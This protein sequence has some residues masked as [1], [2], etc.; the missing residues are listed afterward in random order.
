M[1]VAMPDGHWERFAFTATQD[2]LGQWSAMT[3]GAFG[4]VVENFTNQTFTIWDKSASQYYF[5]YV[6]DSWKIK[7]IT[8]INNNKLTL[9]YDSSGKLSTILDTRGRTM[10]LTYDTAGLLKTVSDGLG[11]SVSYEYNADQQL[12]KFIDRNGKPWQYTYA[13]YG[14]AKLLYEI[15]DPL[16]N[17]LLTNTYDDNARVLT[18]KDALGKISGKLWKMDYASSLTT[19]IDPENTTLYYHIDPIKQMVTKV[20]NND[21]QEVKLTHKQTIQHSQDASLIEDTTNPKGYQ[22]KLSYN[23]PGFGNTSTIEDP[24]NRKTQLGWYENRNQTNQNLVESMSLPGITQPYTLNYGTDKKNLESITNPLTN[25]TQFT[26]NDKGQIT[27]VTDPRGHKTIYEYENY[28]LKQIKDTFSAVLDSNWTFNHNYAIVY[29]YDAMGRVQTVKDRN[30]DVMTY[31]YNANDQV[32]KI[33]DPYSKYVQFNYDDSGNLIKVTDKRLNATE[34]QYNTA[35]L[36]WKTIEKVNIGTINAKTYETIY[37]YDGLNRLVK[38]TNTRQNTSETEYDTLGRVSKTYNPLREY[39]EYIYDK[40][41]N[42]ESITYRDSA[43]TVQKSI[44]YAYDSLD[45]KIYD[46]M[47]PGDGRVLKTNYT[48]YETKG[49]LKT[50]QDPR[51]NITEFEYDDL[52][53]VTKVIDAN[54]KKITEV[55]YDSNGNIIE[56]LDPK[57][58]KTSYQYDALNR[59]VK[60]TDLD[61]KSWLYNYD[62][63]G[64]LVYYENPGTY[65]MSYEYYPLNRL[66]KVSYAYNYESV[67]RSESFTYDD[68]GNAKTMTEAMQSNSKTT[69]YAYDELNRMTSKTDGFGQA[70]GY[71]YDGEDNLTAV[72]YPGNKIVGYDY[73]VVNRMASVSD[74]MGHVTRYEY[75]ALSQVKQILHGNATYVTLSYD[76]AGR[77][78]NYSNLRSSGNVI[79]QYSYYIDDNGNRDNGTVTEP[80]MPPVSTLSADYTYDQL[81][82]LKTMPGVTFDYNVNGNL[83]EEKHA[84]KTIQYGYNFNDRLELWSDGTNTYTYTYSGDQNLI[85][86]KKNGVETRYVLDNSALPNILAR[87]DSAGNAQDYFVYGASGL[88]SRITPDGSYYTYHYDPTGNTIAMTDANQNMV[89]QYAYTPYGKVNELETVDNPFKYNGNFGIMAEDNGLY[90]MRARFYH[91][92]MMRFIS[93]DKKWG[94]V[95][96]P[97]SLNLYAYVQGNPVMGVDPSGLITQDTISSII[98]YGNWI[99]GGIYNI[100]IAI[101]E[102]DIKKISEMKNFKVSIDGYKKWVRS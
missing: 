92:D 42:V 3:T 58:N 10:T 78:T 55:K 46:I 33:T 65:A 19:V 26:Y 54:N 2:G 86:M 95:T 87:T 91:P 79:S 11:R 8:D 34:Y 71:A 74:W 41:N 99:V 45:R 50:T 29:T 20:S 64:N 59:L 44:Q 89:N 69:S 57:T 72:T 12:N 66:K 60:R 28:Y 102:S 61:G 49:W 84:D 63:N 96:N 97:Q 73:D 18:Q 70:V 68:N 100:K 51:G 90:F 40:N 24:L 81:N 36:L 67:D 47:L 98:Q 32:T 27:Q 23:Q 85:A 38:V 22:T 39:V 21:N 6:V 9:N 52:G 48:Y 76:N 56:V 80:L 13:A 82:R 94:S 88:L 93:Q 4:V 43:G 101:N 53:R 17:I 35:N 31:E 7:S 25:K 5:E 77:M 83:H 16:G 15:I 1:Y 14:N 30:N 62:G 75:N 37:E